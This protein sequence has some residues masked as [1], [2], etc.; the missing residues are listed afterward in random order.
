MNDRLEV[1]ILKDPAVRFKVFICTKFGIAIGEKGVE[2][3]G[4]PKYAREQC[5]H[6]LR[7]LNIDQSDLYYQHRARRAPL[8]LRTDPRPDV[9]LS[10]GRP[11]HTY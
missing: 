9:Y 5:E 2:I 6:S 10:I 4:E 8:A 3:H 11:L 1:L 7:N